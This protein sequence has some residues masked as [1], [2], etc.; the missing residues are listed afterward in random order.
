MHD[1]ILKF[2]DGINQGYNTTKVGKGKEQS[3]ESDELNKEDKNYS[4]LRNAS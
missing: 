2:S 3:I 4:S 1:K